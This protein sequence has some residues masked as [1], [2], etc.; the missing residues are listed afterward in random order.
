M[1][2]LFSPQVPLNISDKIQYMFQESSFEVSLPDGTTDVFDFSDFPNGKLDLFDE[3]TGEELIVTE[4]SLNPLQSAKKEDGIL[5]VELLNY[6]GVDATEEER[7][8]D[9]ID[10]TEYIPPVIEEDINGTDEMEE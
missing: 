6:I 7:F 5:Y 10:H 4:L 9:W 8:P 2:I 3:E 1:K